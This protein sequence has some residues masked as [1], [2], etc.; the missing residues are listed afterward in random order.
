MNSKERVIAVLKGKIPDKVPWGEWAVDF[1]TVGKVIGHETFYRAKA[2]SA[3]A[4]WEGRRDEVV[5]SWKEDGIAFFKKMDCFDIIN[6]SAMA[7]SVAPPEDYEFETP[8]KIDDNTWEFKD[9]TIFKSSEITADVTKVFDPHVGKKQYTPAD[10]ECKPV[11]ETPDESC[12]EVV[13]AFIEEFGSDRFLMGP[14]G[15][16]VGIFLLDGNFEE[17]GGGF[18]HGLMQYIDNPDTVKAAIRYEVTKNNFLDRHYIRPGQDSVG[19]GQDFASTK[20]PFISPEMFHEFVLPGIKARVKNIHEQF[21]LPVMKHACGNNTKLLDMFVEAGYDAYQSIQRSAGMDVG[22]I[23]SM[24][25]DHF[26]AWGGIPVENLVSGTQDGVRNDVTNAME[27]YKPGGRYIFGSTHSI[28][29]GTKYDNFM[30]M[31]DEFEKRRGY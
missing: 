11:V 28:A 27:L 10:F 5:Q 14:S 12:F 13:D 22:E 19:W 26:A 21:G 17:G 20:G 23:K 6:I 7:S 18:S 31:V 29:V 1:D 8:K 24:Y 3:I 15:S 30:M 2:R 16:E 9:G 25:G 4:L